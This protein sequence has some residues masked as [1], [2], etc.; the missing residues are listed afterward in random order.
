[1]ST[2]DAVV[3]GSGHNGLVAAAYLARSGMEV[4]VL[5]RNSM[6][7]GAVATEELTL[8]GFHHDTFS[9]FH[10]VFKLSA[11]WAELGDE[12]TA[13][14]LAYCES[15]GPTTA[16]VLPDGRAV[17]AYRDIEETVEQL[18]PHDRD[19]YIAEMNSFHQRIGTLGKLMGT[20]LFSGNA[21]ML[22]LR[23]GRSL[24]RRPG[25]AFGA[26]I[27]NSAQAWLDSRFQGREVAD[28]YAPWALHTGLSPDAAGSGFQTLAI[29]ASLHAM[30]LPVVAG[31]SGNFVR[32]I[33]RLI[34]DYGGQVTT[35]AEVERILT[36]SGRA[37]GVETDGARYRV[38]SAVIA[39]TTPTQLYGRLLADGDAPAEAV[40]QA[41]RYRYNPRAGMQIHMALTAP[42]RWKD[43]RLD[44]VPLIH[45][46]SGAESVALACAESAAG[47]LPADPT[48]VVGQPH[49]LDPSRAPEGRS[50]L[51]IQLQQVP[52]T[53]RGDAAGE[54]DTGEGTWSDRLRDAWVD[55]ILAKVAAH[56]ENFAEARGPVASL[57]PAD[58]ERR[59]PNL[60][61]GDIYAG[62]CDLGQSY[63]W[64]P[65]PSFGSH[66]TPVD[67]LLQCGASTYPGQG[68]NAASGR[69]VARQVLSGSGGLRDLARRVGARRR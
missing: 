31:G 22:A 39:N 44:S 47:L 46:H 50:V 67:G 42:L 14:G 61:H 56:V 6:A 5:E 41:R 16:A 58:I 36:H 33:E 53:P 21:A 8:P 49:V 12:L 27:L 23:L 57:T 26:D 1:M 68:L 29:A 62:A 10:T 38:R 63:L 18:T 64:R 25:L 59:N 24:G 35:G 32:A 60:V 19:A 40:D 43:S 65:L 2:R 51:W 4:E 17:I 13:R 11:A 28:L 30:G 45:I 66:V 9:S 3:I 20:E 34:T 52:Y 69:I 7:G 55:R 48:I 37:V 54:I 15:E